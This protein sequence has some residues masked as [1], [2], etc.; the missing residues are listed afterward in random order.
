MNER[1]K[2]VLNII[3][4]RFQSGDIPEAIAYAMFPFTDV[5][6]ANWSL[7]NRTLMFLSGTMDARGYRQWQKVN[8][9]V[10]KGSKALYIIVPYIKVIEDELDERQHALKG[11][12]LSPVFPVEATAG[13]DLEY[14]NIALP[15][16]PLLRRAEEFGVSVK[17]IPG[18]CR[19]FGYFSIDRKEIAIATSQECVFFHELAHCSYSIIKGGL[20]RGQDPL[21]E[22]VA[23]LSAQALAVMVGK[24][25]E[26]TTGNS[27]RYIQKYAEQLNISVEAACLK[28]MSDSE[29]VLH[30]ILYGGDVDKQ[31]AEALA[32]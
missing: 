1:V 24:S 11:F 6:S 26:D 25:A 16:I 7:L 27:Y 12:G 29:K 9:Y 32:A 10:K 8:R 14:E 17:A 22:I 18:N 21:Q 15:D 2:N 19:Y 28:V 13:A 5:P 4:G 31:P 23:E 20:K 30:L 3:V